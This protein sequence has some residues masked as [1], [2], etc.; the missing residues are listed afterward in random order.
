MSGDIKALAD[1]VFTSQNIKKEVVENDPYEK[2]QR[3]ILNFGHTLGHAIEKE[4][5]FSLSHGVCVGLG[6]LA[7]F[8]ICIKKNKLSEDDRKFLGDLMAIYSL[9]TGTDIDVEKV[10]EATSNDKKMEAGQIKFVL[11][12]KIGDAY[13]DRNVN[14]EDMVEALKSICKEI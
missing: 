14:K 6:M 4:K 7:A 10:F 3:A 12:N 11:L 8:D 9:E 2:G 13:I 5:N 1:M